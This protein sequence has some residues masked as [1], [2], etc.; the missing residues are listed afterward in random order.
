MTASDN[1]TWT[2]L[3]RLERLRGREALRRQMLEQKAI[4]SDPATFDGW[5][6]QID[7]C[8][9]ELRRLGLAIL[10]LRG[11]RLDGGGGRV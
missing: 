8:D 11:A 3:A 10:D 5:A 1:G 2:E 4:N 9:A 7:A 6:D